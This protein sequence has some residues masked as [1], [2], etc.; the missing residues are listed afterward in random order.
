MFSNISP[1]E[2][3]LPLRGERGILLSKY[4]RDMY[5]LVNQDLYYPANTPFSAQYFPEGITNARHEDVSLKHNIVLMGYSARNS[6]GDVSVPVRAVFRWTRLDNFWRE[7][8]VMDIASY[9]EMMNYRIGGDIVISRQESRLL[10][11]NTDNPEAMFAEKIETAGITA[12]KVSKP[13]FSRA[14]GKDDFDNNAWEL[15]AVKLKDHNQKK[16]AVTI[17]E[18]NNIFT[19]KNIDAKA[20]T[21]ETFAGA[22][23]G[24]IKGIRT[25]LFVFVSL[26]FIVAIIIIMNTL[27]MSTLERSAELGMMRAV[28]ARRKFI[29]FMLLGETFTLSAIFGGLGIICGGLMSAIFSYLKLPVKNEMMQIITGNAWY[30]P[31]FTAADALTGIILLILVTVLSVIYPLRISFRISPLDAV[32]RN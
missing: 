26:I 6:S 5:Y 25:G 15:I 19:E 27:A 17:R 32:E 31:E 2:G 14:A 18:L 20:V 11:I 3:K 22:M 4:M 7:V 9:R 28:G 16:R 12:Q 24:F 30:A 13:E 8:S 29:G 21:W 1:V 23:A 10:E